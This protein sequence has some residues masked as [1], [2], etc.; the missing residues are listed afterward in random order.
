MTVLF[1]IIDIVEKLDGKPLQGG[2]GTS[3]EDI[4]SETPVCAYRSFA[5]F[6]E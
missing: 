3:Y 1:D 6:A 5:F 2:P 4:S